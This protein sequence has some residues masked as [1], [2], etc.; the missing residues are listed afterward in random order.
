VKLLA[1]NFHYI[2]EGLSHPY[3]AVYPVEPDR[4]EAQLVELGAWFDFVSGEQLLAALEGESL[5]RRACVITF[6]DGLRSQYE[7][8]LPI[9]DRLGVPALF[10]VPC[11]PQQ[12]GRAL[13][14]HKIH[15]VRANVSPATMLAELQTSLT[16]AGVDET[17]LESARTRAEN[18]YRY[19]DPEAALVKWYLNFGLSSEAAERVVSELFAKLVDDEGAW[20]ERTYMGK[21]QIRDLAARNY[22]GNHTFDHLPL[23]GLAP[24]A[25]RAQLRRNQQALKALGGRP[26]PFVSYP[27]GGENAVGDREAAACAALGFRIGFTMERSLNASLQRPLMLARVDTNDALGGKKPMMSVRDGSLHLADGLGA[28]RRRYF[29]ESAEIGI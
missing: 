13:N 26:T 16:A 18:T 25:M 12:E 23:A 19:D 3:P 20:C 7:N 27:Y 4:L 11:R 1:V 5:P 17:E 9:L 22:L 15:F 8:A 10:F 6:D 21:E 24:D 14:V 29:D 2:E 28:E